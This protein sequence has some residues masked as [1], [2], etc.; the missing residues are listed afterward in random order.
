LAVSVHFCFAGRSSAWPLR[1][2]MPA[3]RWVVAELE[4]A[5]LLKEEQ[6]EVVMV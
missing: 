2:G 1:D 5:G 6:E 4:E 3:V